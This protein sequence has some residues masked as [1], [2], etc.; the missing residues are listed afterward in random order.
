MILHCVFCNFRDD[1]IQAEQ[2]ALFSELEILCQSLDGAQAFHHG[3]NRDFEHKSADFN[4]GFVIRFRDQ[5]ALD[6]YAKHPRHQALGAKLCTLCKEGANGI[7]VFDL[8]V[9]QNAD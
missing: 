3:P 6:H 5:T 4:A 1:I 7:I 9:S 2:T 8:E